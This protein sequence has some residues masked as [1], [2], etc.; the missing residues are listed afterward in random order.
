MSEPKLVLVPLEPTETMCRAAESSEYGSNS[1]PWIDGG[2]KPENV[3]GLYRAMIA[4][5]PTPEVEPVLYQMW[6]KNL[7]TYVN[8]SKAVADTFAARN[9]GHEIRALYTHPAPPSELVKAA[10]EVYPL[11]QKA[12]FAK[13][14]RGFDQSALMEAT[15]RLKTELDKVKP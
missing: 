1:G 14:V 9:E 7:P 13:D 2:Y 6:H 8:C 10:E 15:I 11:L 3:E 4:A 12:I 5:A